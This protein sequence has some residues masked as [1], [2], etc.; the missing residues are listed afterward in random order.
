[1]R[2]SMKIF[3]TFGFT[4]TEI[5]TVRNEL[6]RVLQV[7]FVEHESEFFGEYFAA[8][9]GDEVYKLYSNL[10][11]KDFHEEE[12]QEYPILFSVDHVQEKE[13]FINL[14][15]QNELGAK[16][17]SRMEMDEDIA[18]SYRFNDEGKAVLIDSRK[19]RK[20]DEEKR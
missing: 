6:E 19:I 7:K 9:I 11:D 1:M 17:L 14:S 3:A 8:S 12:F 20:K 5:D 13:R 4:E 2:K 10:L 15:N 16:A 18:N